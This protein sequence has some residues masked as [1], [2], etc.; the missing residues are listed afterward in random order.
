MG[1]HPKGL[2]RAPDGASLVARLLGLADELAL[3]AVLVGDAG[4][5]QA[6]C[7]DH[8]VVSDREAGCGP[9]GGLVA[10]L[11][12]AGDRQALVLSCDLPYV[13]A[14]DVR[15]LLDH[16]SQAPVVCGRASPEAPLEPL[17]ARYDA[18]RALACAEGRLARRELSLQRLL[19]ALEADW[20]V[21]A[22]PRALLDWD[23]PEDVRAGGGSFG[24]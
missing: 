23:T 9:L 5:Y 15:E 24:T 17:F 18:S 10:L 16:P 20:F 8:A 22:S 11:A 19:V 7:R 6:F 12:R 2:L 1:R 14:Q 3:E 13:Q 21:P 4:P